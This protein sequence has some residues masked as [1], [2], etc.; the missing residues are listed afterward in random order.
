[1]KIEARYYSADIQN[2]QNA[3]EHCATNPVSAKVTDLI[4]QSVRS[5][6]QQERDADTDHQAVRDFCILAGRALG[7]AKQLV[8]DVEIEI[9]ERHQGDIVFEMQDLYLAGDTPEQVKHT[10][11]EIAQR[12]DR[13]Y[14]DSAVCKIRLAFSY[15]LAQTVQNS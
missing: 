15:N 14:M 9:N 3:A 10:L 4:H 5:Y 6:F 13:V 2:E 12:A 11:F 8:A 7:I 1:M